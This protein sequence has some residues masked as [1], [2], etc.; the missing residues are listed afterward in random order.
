LADFWAFLADF[1]AFLADFWAFLADFWAFFLWGK[2]VKNAQ[3]TIKRTFPL[4]DEKNKGVS[5]HP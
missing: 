5:T 2:D 4:W 1:W 3:K